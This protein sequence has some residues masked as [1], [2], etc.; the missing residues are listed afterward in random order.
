MGARPSGDAAWAAKEGRTALYM[1]EL[2][3]ALRVERKEACLAEGG[4]AVQAA[5]SAAPP[6]VMH[7]DGSQA[8]SE[9]MDWNGDLPTTSFISLFKQLRAAGLNTRVAI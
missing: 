6:S 8:S 2:L 1:T 7:L 3:A 5:A 4:V 9:L